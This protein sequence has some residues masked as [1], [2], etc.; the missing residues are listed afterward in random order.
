M[1]KACIRPFLT[2]KGDIGVTNLLPHLLYRVLLSSIHRARYL[3]RKITMENN[4]NN[5]SRMENVDANAAERS[6]D[7]ASDNLR[8][9]AL[10][11]YQC[12]GNGGIVTNPA[13]CR[14]MN[15]YQLPDLRIQA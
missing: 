14:P 5:N 1:K 9:Q 2:F 7:R 15:G 3:G 8:E 11:L 13:D 10:R 12:P 6:A 4:N